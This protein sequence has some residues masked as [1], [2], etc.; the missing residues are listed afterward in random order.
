MHVLTPGEWVLYPCQCG[1]PS[2][3]LYGLSNGHFHIGSGFT[4]A[5]ATLIV[6]AKRL[7]ELVA[8]DVLV[9]S[10][11]ARQHRAKGSAESTVKAAVNETLAE[12]RREILKKITEIDE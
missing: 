12:E 8:E 10:E 4:L 7:M 11:Y 9:F 1:H 5:D 6:N 2:C 3:K